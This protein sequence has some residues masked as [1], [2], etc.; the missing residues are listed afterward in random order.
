MDI[1]DFEGEKSNLPIPNL[2]R[3]SKDHYF[4]ISA[5]SVPG[6]FDAFWC[7]KI[8]IDGCEFESINCRK[9]PPAKEGTIVQLSDAEQT[10]LIKRSFLM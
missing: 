6:E 9:C 5:Y 4:C 10:F 2:I 8:R 1:Q 3:G 7:K